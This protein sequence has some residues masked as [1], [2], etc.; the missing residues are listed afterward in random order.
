MPTIL[1][2][3]LA[4]LL[5]KRTLLGI[6]IILTILLLNYDKVFQPDPTVY[7]RI[8]S[9]TVVEEFRAV[10]IASVANINW[11]SERGLSVAQ[12]KKEAID[13]LDTVVE[14]N[15]NAVI[16]QIRPQADALYQSDYEPWSY[17]LSGEQGIAPEPLYDPLEFWVTE[18]RQRGLELHAWINPYRAHH[19]DGGP[20]SDHSMV[21]KLGKNVYRLKNDMY[22]MD[23]TQPEVVQHSLAVI[24]DIVSRYDI[25]GLHY[26]DYFYPYPSYNEGAAFPDADNYQDYAQ[27]GGELSIGDWR[28]KAVDDFVKAIY[29]EVKAIKP[30]VK[31][32]ISPFGIYRPGTPRH[33]QGFDQYAELYADAKLWLNQGWL[34]Y[35]TPQLYW[36]IS[37]IPQSFPLLLAWWESENSQQRHL[38]PGLSSNKAS[39]PSGQ[40]E[41]INQIMISRALLGEQT[42]HVFWNVKTIADNPDFAQILKENIYNNQALIPPSPWLNN[43]PPLSPEVSIS[44]A[45]NNL[46]LNW[47]E[48][49]E[50]IA[51]RWLLYYKVGGGWQYKILPAMQTSYSFVDGTEITEVTVQA[52]SRT[53]IRSERII[54]SVAQHKP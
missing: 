40:T 43:Q 6:I 23:P 26:D 52:I 29:E 49:G 44:S 35:F 32:G 39:T 27:S 14:A 11:P 46:S 10:W 19:K 22:W 20:V 25:D 34:D 24:K 47:S 17:Y 5:N 7:G 33:I 36:N 21:N 53:G 30:H 51:S 54:N 45:D 18:A 31:V 50:I 15:M 8:T 3:F 4:L 28:R 42:G 41:V 12:Q 9:E 2:S 1:H 48:R 16:L 38:W 13:L 37:K